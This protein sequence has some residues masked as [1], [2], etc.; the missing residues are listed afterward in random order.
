MLTSVVLVFVVRIEFNVTTHGKEAPGVESGRTPFVILAHIIRSCGD[1]GYEVIGA[2]R[3]GP[4]NR[5]LVSIAPG[6]GGVFPI[7]IGAVTV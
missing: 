5:Q 1:V 3:K 7:E 6:K 4:L 2:D